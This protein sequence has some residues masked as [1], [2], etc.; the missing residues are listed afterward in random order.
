MKVFVVVKKKVG[1]LLFIQKAEVISKLIE[2]I[3][4]VLYKICFLIVISNEVKENF[5][6]K[7]V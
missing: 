4:L 5:I 1:I 2:F 7:M 3:F 6:Q